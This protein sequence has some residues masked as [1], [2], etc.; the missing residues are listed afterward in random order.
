[1]ASSGNEWA[2][3]VEGGGGR[4]GCEVGEGLGSDDAEMAAVKYMCV[5]MC[6]S[7]CIYVDIFMHV[8]M[9]VHMYVCI[10]ASA[11]LYVRMCTH[12]YSLDIFRFHN[13]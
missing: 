11:R 1:M 8:C 9:Y 12:S 13:P 5:C 2:W 6:V 3:L 4:G 10:L 7:V